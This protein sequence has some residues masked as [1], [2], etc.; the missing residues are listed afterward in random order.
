MPVFVCVYQCNGNKR[1]NRS[2]GTMDNEIAG[3]N[4]E[5]DFRRK[6][7]SSW[8]KWQACGLDDRQFAE[9]GTAGIG[10]DRV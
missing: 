4:F 5:H 3:V 2:Y 1:S 9:R 8:E 6:M 10:S 7:V